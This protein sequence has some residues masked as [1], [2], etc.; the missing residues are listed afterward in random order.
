ML[1][2]WNEVSTINVERKLINVLLWKENLNTKKH[3]WKCLYF[4][5]ELVAINVEIK[6]INVLLWKENL[7]TKK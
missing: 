7:D 4:G 5:T 3:R 6:V 1:I 2:F